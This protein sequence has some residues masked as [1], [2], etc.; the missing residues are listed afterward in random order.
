[1]AK[2]YAVRRGRS[3]GV[4]NSWPD[5]YKQV[6][7]FSGCEHKSF[8][9]FREAERYVHSTSHTDTYSPPAFMPLSPNGSPSPNGVNV[10]EG[11]VGEDSQNQELFKT[12]EDRVK[13]LSEEVEK[14]A[15][16]FLGHHER[17][18]KVE[19][20]L[21]LEADELSNQGEFFEEGGWKDRVRW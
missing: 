1:M 16:G 8:L 18:T 4:Y 5:C 17:I 10:G 12:I 14:L 6:H 11:R 20:H 15:E 2:F 19:R 3:P 13:V 21:N 9:T 7:G